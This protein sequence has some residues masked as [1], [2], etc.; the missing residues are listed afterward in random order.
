IRRTLLMLEILSRRFFLKLNLSDHKSILT[1]LQYPHNLLQPLPLIPDNRGRCVIPFEHFINNDLEYLWGGASSRKYT[2]SVTKTKAA[3]YGHIKWIEDLVPREMWI[4]Q[5]IDYNKHAL[6]GVSHWGRKRKQFYGYAVNRKSARDVYSK[7]RIIAVEPNSRD[8]TNDVV[9]DISP[10]KEPQILNSLPTHPT[11]QLNMKFQPSSEYL[12]TYVVW[13]FLPF[14]VYSVASHY[15]LSLRNEDAIFDPGIFNSH[16]SRPDVSH[17]HQNTQQFGALLPIE[18]T[19]KEIRNSNAYKGYYAVATRAAPPK[20]KASVKRTRSSSDTSITPPTA[21]ANK[22]VK[23]LE[24]GKNRSAFIQGEMPKRMED[25]GLFTLPCRLWDSKPFD[26]L[27]DLGDVEVHIE[28]LKL[29]NDFYVIDMKKDLKTPLLVGRGFL[30]T[31]NAIIDCSKAKIMYLRLAMEVLI[32]YQAYGNLYATIGRKAYLLEDKKILSVGEEE[33]ELLADP[34][35]AETSSNQYVITNNAAYQADDLDAYDS[36]CDELNSAKI[37]LMANLSHYGSGNLEKSMEIETLKHTLSEHLKEKKSLEQKAFETR[38]VPQSELSAEQAFWSRLKKLKFHLASFDMVVKERTTATAITEGTWGFEHTKACFRDDMIPFV[39]ALK[40]LFNSFDQFL[41]V[42]LTEVQNVFKQMEQAVEQHC[43]KKNKFQDKMNNVLKDNDRLLKQAISIDIVNIVVHDHSQAKNTVILKLKEILQS[44]SGDV[45]EKKVKRKVEE[46]EMINIEFDHRVTKLVAE[47]EHLKQTY[48]QLL[49]EKDLVII[50]LKETLS[51]LK[52]KAVVN[53]AVSLHSIDPDLLKIDV[54]PLAPKLR[55]NKIAHTD[56]L[57]HTQEE[58]TTLREIVERNTSVK[59][60]STNIASNT[61]V[62]YSTRVNLLSSASGSQPQGNTKNDRIQRTPRKA[63]KDKLQDYPGTVFQIVLWYLDPGCSKHM[64]GDRSQLINFVQKFLGTVKFG[65]D[66]VAKIIGYGDYRIGNVTILRVYFVEGLGPNLFSMGQFCDLDLEVACRQHTCFICNLDGVDL[67]TGF[68]G[69]N[70]YTLS[71]QDIMTSSPI[72]LLSKASKTKS[73]LWHHHLSHLN[74]GAVNHL[75]RQSLVRGLL[76]LK[77]EKDHLC[78]GCAMGKST[79]KSH[80]PKSEDT[81]QEKLYLLRM[82]LCNPLRVES[83]NGNKYILVT[84]DDYSR[85]TWVNFLRSKD[86]APDFIIKFLK[87]IQMTPTTISLGLVQK[88][89]PSTSYV[90][91]LRNDWDLLFQPMFDELLNPPPS[92]D[93]QAA[94]VIALIA[95]VIPPVQSDSTGSPS[96]TTVD[97]DAPSPNKV[98]VITLKWIY[99]VKLDE[100]G[101]IL[102]NKARLVSRG[103][104]QEEGIDFEESFAPVARLE[105]IRIFLAYAAHKNMVVYHMDLKIAFL[106]GN[107]REEVYVSQPDGF[108]DQDNPNHVYKLKKALYVLKQALR[109]WYDMLSSFLISQDFSKRSVDLTLFIRRNDNDLLLVQIYVDDIIFAASTPELCDLFANLMCSKFKMSMMGNISFFL[110]LQISQSP[111]V[112][113]INQ[114]KYALESLKKYGFESCDPVDTPMDS[115]VALIAFTDADHAGCQDTR[116]STSEQVENG[117][118]ELYFVNTEYQLADLFT[119]ALGRD[120]TEFLINKLRK[121]YKLVIKKAK[122]CCYFRY[123]SGIHLLIWMLCPKRNTSPYLDVVPKSYG[124]D[125]NLRTMALDS[126]KSLCTAIIKVLLFYAAIMSNTLG[127]CISTSDTISSQSRTMDTT[128]EQQVAMDEALVPH[129]Q[130]LRIGRSNFCLLSDIKSKE[131]TLPLV[132]DFLR[133]CP[134]FKAFLVTTDVPEIYMQEFWATATVHHHAIRFNM[135]N[136]KHIVNLESFRDM[137]HICPRVQGQYFDEPPFEEEILAF[138]HFLGHSAAIRTLTDVNNN[139][140][141]QPWRSF[142][143]IINKYLTGKSSGYDS[144]RLSQAQILW[145]LYHKRNVNYAYLMWE[146][147]VYQVEHKNHKKSNEMYYPRF[148]KVIIHHFMSK[149]PL[150]PRRNKVNW[151]Y[152]RDDHMLSMIKLVSKHQNTQQFSALLPI[153]LRNEEIRKF[154]AYKEYYAVSTGAAPPKPKASVRK[155]RS[156]KASKAKSLSALSEVSMT[157]AQQLKLVTKR[158]QQQTHISQA[159]GSGADESKEELFWNSTDDEGADDE[160][161]NDDDDKEDEGDDGEEGDGNDDEEGRDE[162][163]DYDVEEYAEET[164][165]EESFDPIPH[166]EEEEEDGLYRD[167]NINRGR[168]IQATLEVEDS[169]VTLTPVNPDGM[170]SIF[171]T[172]SQLDV[173]TPTSVAPLPMTAPTMTP[174]TIA[175]IT[176]TSQAPIL[177]TTAPNTIIQDLVN[178]SSLFGFDNRLRTLEANFSKFT[179][180]NQFAGEVSAIPGTVQRYMDQRMNDAMKVAVQIQSDR[181]RDA[182]QRENDE[183]LKY[184]VNEQLEAEVLTQSS[185]SSKTSYA[186][187]A[188]LFEMELKKILIEKMEGNKRRD[189]DADKDEEPS[190]GPDRGSKRQREGK[191]PK[192]ASALREIITRSAGR[193]TQGSRSRQASASESALAEEPMQT[194][195]QIEEPSHPEFDTG[196]EDQPIPLSLIP[197][198]RG[199][200][201]IPFEHFINNDLEYLR[202]GASSRKYTT[203]IMK[204]KRADYEHIKWIEDLV[205]RTMWIEEPIRYDKHALWGVSYWGRKRQQFYGFAIN[206]DSARDVYSKRRIIVVTELKIVEWHSYKHL[207]WITVRR[208]DDKL[209]KFKE[210]DLKRLRIQDIKDI[211][212]LLVQGKLTNL[213][214]EERFSF[215]VSLRMFTKSI[216]IQRRVEDLQLGVES[217]Q[218]KLN[219][220]KPD[221][222]GTLTDVH[223]ALDDGLKGMRMQYLP[224]LIWRKS[225][226][227]RAAAMI[228]AID[229]RLKT[230]RIM[231][232]LERFVGGRLYKETS[233]CYKGQYD[234]SYAALIRLKVRMYIIIPMQI[235]T[236]CL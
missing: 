93:H 199:H 75:A 165:D 214:V 158:S 7:R 31:A 123:G 58:T 211:L 140:L 135:D 234:L 148:T 115:S 34:G 130:R 129:A 95:D 105:A 220:T 17:R 223:T 6:W 150:I 179:Q 183:F 90:P 136:K 171:E 182:A 181:L 91:P 82:D 16:F 81:N 47:N 56:Y 191:E 194:T 53:V 232:S 133:I 219:L 147:F 188:D 156:T 92:V 114:S 33:L 109:A 73:W 66:H 185:H 173:Q 80:K 26:T 198:N 204:T 2:T 79:K 202:G 23:S 3:D 189:D 187:V 104:R 48:K 24:L 113:F 120:R 128:I 8:F 174:S 38:F 200:R 151:H 70:L 42:E 111:K 83:V 117:V 49:Q 195:S 161:K 67:L 159:S 94:E 186:I 153:G 138:I 61:P 36:N 124:C 88:S 100:L 98:M 45:K 30:A 110:G 60:S 190:T 197:N 86:E 206:R 89:S 229:K 64:T 132:Y 13:I 152:V 203:S 44:L 143:A 131:S 22:Y 69:N 9:E 127:L 217:Y 175:T 228:Q 96:S 224:Q 210:G 41:I 55:N 108:V 119:K 65:N 216:V 122:E 160:G 4:Q 112:I 35:I 97:Q 145:G 59:T 163:Q 225:D 76:K 162:D 154:N 164:R 139:K 215:N 50:A 29:I 207:D 5:P 87:M 39:K 177:P 78:S 231:R 172:T 146:D 142:A 213:T 52:G 19:I 208:D 103:Y 176:T 57:R 236:N 169:Y 18:L 221:T 180:T 134:F 141:Y 125:H 43:V 149:D 37:A 226:K 227:E 25:P 167:V 218:K 205:P 222:D 192:S 28:R 46:I 51:K 15:L 212:L 11:L 137:L 21:A 77:F 99:K 20:P 1:N 102:K 126:I 32:L 184:T 106:N 233:G 12:F 178:F 157:E 155:T 201:V 107:L 68:R 74:F 54:A 85:F 230:R 118:I 170:E 193:S 101:G 10:T 84:V 235:L 166:V 121:A 168:G 71:L 14:L 40:E 27:A 116:Q 209:Y 196:A 144:L 63:K 72:Y 62:L